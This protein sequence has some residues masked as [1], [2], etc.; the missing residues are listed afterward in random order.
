VHVVPVGHA[1]VLQSERHW[2]L[3]QTSPA[4]HWL[5][6]WQEFDVAVHVPATH[7]WFAAQSALVVQG[8]GPRSPPQVG[9]LSFPA[10]GVELATQVCETH[11]S[12][13]GQS[14]F[15]VHCTGVPGVVPGGTHRFPVLFEAH[16]VPC[17]QSPLFEQ[18]CSQPDV[19]QT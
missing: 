18:L 4:G 14:A 3:S 8:Q 16:T 13:V 5:E 1:A 2:P 6:Y 17:G 12:P 19:V 9:P 15:V 10:S 7:A 11:A